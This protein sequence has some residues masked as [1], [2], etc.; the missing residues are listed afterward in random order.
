MAVHRGI[1]IEYGKLASGISSNSCG[2]GHS[3]LDEI[4]MIQQVTGVHRNVP[5]VTTAF[6]PYD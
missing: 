5:T 1:H 6:A 2:D 4:C 3:E